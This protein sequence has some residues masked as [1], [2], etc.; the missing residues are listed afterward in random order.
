MQDTPKITPTVGRILIVFSLLYVSQLSA[1]AAPPKVDF[2]YPAGGQLGTTVEVTLGGSVAPWP[3]EIWASH[4]G[5]T[6]KAAK[7][8]GEISVTI[9][10]D[11]P[12][13]MH[14]L[15]VYNADGASIAK[16]F[17][18]GQL[19]EKNEKEP[20]DRTEQANAT[21]QN[22]VFNGSL[23]KNGDVDC[24][25]IDAK[26]GQTI[27]ASL[28]A[29]NILG[30]P[31]DAIL[32]LTDLQGN[33]LQQN[34]DHQGL[35]P[36]IAFPVAKDGQ[37]VVRVFAFPATPSSSIRFFGSTDSVYRLSLTTGPW[38]DSTWPLAVQ[39][40]KAEKVKLIGWNIPQGTMMAPSQPAGVVSLPG[41]GNFATVLLENHPTLVLKTP[42]EPLELPV[43]CSCQLPENEKV[44]RVQF[45]AK[46]GRLQIDCF[47][48]TPD[49]AITPTM[50]LLDAAQKQVIYV[51]P[52]TPI[53]KPVLSTVIRTA[54]QYTLEVRDLYQQASP[55][56]SFAVRIV[57]P[58][59]DF[60][61]IIAE[62]HW[63]LPLKGQLDLAVKVEKKDGYRDPIEWKVTGLP[64]DVGL[65]V[66][67]AGKKPTD[68]VTIRLRAKKAFPAT[69]FQIVGTSG[70]ISKVVRFS[71]PNGLSIDQ[72]W[73]QSN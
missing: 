56:S 49:R 48:G 52:R 5:I 24:F 61:A 40:S 3:A 71:H 46:P 37:Y 43:T 70:A 21:D 67:P 13:G 9:A 72:L 16:P 22:V 26:A 39:E 25:A 69:T 57:Q 63:V 20:N 17:I 7:K 23:Q 44:V 4:S 53:D 73:L 51:E 28:Q 65:E 59:P 64:A 11:T 45:L 66:L 19:L 30:A 50:R 6:A 15:R 32:Q 12:P 42:H 8:A 18:V 68:P 29:N 27:V 34:H 41:G 58:K 35:D 33:V 47:P 31:V 14:W 38:L 60:E 54:G 55:R 1:F 62:D 10:K 2:L 36:Q